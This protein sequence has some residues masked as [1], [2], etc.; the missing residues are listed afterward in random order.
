[1]NECRIRTRYEAIPDEF[2]A[3]RDTLSRL[4]IPVEIPPETTERYPVGLGEDLRGLSACRPDRRL[5][6]PH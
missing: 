6:A 3:D 2:A 4:A 5:Q 1:M